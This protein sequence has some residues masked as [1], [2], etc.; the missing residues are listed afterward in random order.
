M[1]EN[2]LEKD[3]QAKLIIGG[4]F[5]FHI[6]KIHPKM[7]QF[8]LTGVIAR[9]NPTHID[10]NLIDQIYTNGKSSQFAISAPTLADGS[11]L[12]DHHTVQAT[13]SFENSRYCK[14]KSQN[15]IS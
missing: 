10:G 14:P 2:I 5:N 6:S 3:R 12:S 7:I 8:G 9:G 13:I 4:D 15:S 1:V 11:T